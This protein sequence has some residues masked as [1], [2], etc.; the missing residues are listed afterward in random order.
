MKKRYLKSIIGNRS[1][2]FM[3]P[4]TGANGGANPEGAEGQQGEGNGDEGQSSDGDE[5][6]SEAGKGGDNDVETIIAERIKQAKA[7]WEKELEDQKTEAEKLKD[8]TKEQKAQYEQEKRIKQL[9]ERERR[10]NERELRAT[11][12]ETL[13]EK[14]LPKELI[15]TLSFKDADACNNSILAVEKAFKNALDAKVTEALRGGKVPKGKSGSDRAL[16]MDDLK[17]MSA[18]EINANWDKVKNIK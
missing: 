3:A 13:A 17:T 5:E 6:E 9:E 10:L 2:K 18:A 7:E 8:M 15:D 1:N 14:G 12:Y 16:T 4:D 11:A